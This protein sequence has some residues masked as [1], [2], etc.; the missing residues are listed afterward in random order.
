MTCYCPKCLMNM[1]L[2]NKLKLSATDMEN[3]IALSKAFNE[4]CRAKVGA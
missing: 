3:L 1:W 2:N 4:P